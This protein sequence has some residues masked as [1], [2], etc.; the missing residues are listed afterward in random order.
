MSTEN[1]GKINRWAFMCKGVVYVLLILI[2]ACVSWSHAVFAQSRT[3]KSPDKTLSIVL[4]PTVT[5]TDDHIYL[6]HVLETCSNAALKNDI[7]DLSL[8]KAPRPGK[9]KILRGSRIVSRLQSQKGLPK[10]VEISVPDSI[11]VIRAHQSVS[12]K[13]LKEIFRDFIAK[14][15]KG[16]DFKVD[17]FAVRGTD[18]FPSGQ[19]RLTLVDAYKKNLAGRVNLS[20]RVHVD[21]KEAGK[22]TLSGWVNQYAK[23]VCADRFLARNTMLEAKDLRRERI[24]ISKAPR[25]LVTDTQAAI[26]KRLKQSV[27]AGQYLRDNMLAV[28]PLV[29]KGDKVKIIAENGPLKIVTTGIAK[30]SGGL[31]EQIKVENVTSQKTIVGRIRDA[32]TV[33]VLF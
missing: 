4:K 15:M 14:K 29:R 32:S 6:K 9:E 27:K 1:I 24:N 23:V 28:P 10:T 7:K 5:V 12:K 25:N 21:G 19:I 16:S 31:G 8:G 3:P 20:V 13:A 22:I 18:K 17:R 30:G 26:G 33:E 11:R 2:I